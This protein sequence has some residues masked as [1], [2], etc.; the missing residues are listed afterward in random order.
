MKVV[1]L[2]FL[3]EPVM[4]T[5]KKVL[6]DRTVPRTAC[7]AALVFGCDAASPTERFAARAREVIAVAVLRI[8]RPPVFDVFDVF[9]MFYVFGVFDVSGY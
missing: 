5:M 8:A 7:V 6:I 9:D 2:G 1:S 3:A 4:A